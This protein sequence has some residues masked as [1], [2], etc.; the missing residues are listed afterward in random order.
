MPT[1]TVLTNAPD[2]YDYSYVTQTGT[3]DLLGRTFRVVTMPDDCVAY[4]CG[5]YQSGL[6]VAAEV[7]A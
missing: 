2:A 4:Q 3:V 7:T 6:Y 1:T 5:R